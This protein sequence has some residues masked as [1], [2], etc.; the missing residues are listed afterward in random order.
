MDEVDAVVRDAIDGI[1]NMSEQLL[2]VAVAMPF[3][4]VLSPAVAIAGEVGRRALDSYAKPDNVISIDMRMKIAPKDEAELQ[5]SRPEK[6]MRYGYYFF[7][8]KKVNARLFAS[9]MTSEN[10]VLVMRKVSSKVATSKQD[11]SSTSK[12]SSAKLDK[13]DSVTTATSVESTADTSDQTYI[14]LEK[15]SYLVVR[16]GIPTGDE[17][18]PEKRAPKLSPSMV[19]RLQNIVE[20][21]ES[22]DAKIV[23]ENI[24]NIM[25]QVRGNAPT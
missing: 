7:L 23:K 1:S 2:T 21:A 20:T 6:Y 13:S 25:R 4:S 17:D 12:G 22:T 10:L 8:S 5:A 16:V 3:L 14:P 11:L 19:S 15:V 9:T 24:V 18:V